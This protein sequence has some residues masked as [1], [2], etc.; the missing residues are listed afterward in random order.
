[1]VED[2][3]VFE[4]V[5]VC[6]FVLDDVCDAGSRVC[7]LSGKV[8]VRLLQKMHFPVKLRFKQISAANQGDI[9]PTI[10]TAAELILGFTG[11]S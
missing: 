8:F 11:F 4:Q 5:L 1:M 2:K 7:C 3:S 10:E 9:K 6:E